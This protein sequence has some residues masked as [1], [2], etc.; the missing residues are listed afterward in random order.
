MRFG[1]KRRT[2]MVLLLLLT[3]A[4]FGS[5]LAGCGNKKATVVDMTGEEVAV[6]KNPKRIYVDWSEGTTLL[7]A[8]RATKKLVVAPPSFDTEV[9]TNMKSICPEI[10]SVEKDEEAYLSIEKA[11]SYEPDLVITNMKDNIPTYRDAGVAV[12]HV[13]YND[14]ETFQESLK[15]VGKALGTKAYKL[16]NSYCDYFASNEEMVKQKLKDIDEESKPSVYYI[17]ARYSDIYHT[18]GGGEFQETWITTAGGVL[19]TTAEYKG[20][21]L[22]LSA[23]EILSLNPDIILIGEWNQDK[24]YELL[25]NDEKL[26]ALK[27]VE[28]GRVYCVPRGISTWSGAGAEAALQML[29]AAKLFH[30]EKFADIDITEST[31]VF[32][33][34]IYGTKL[35]DDTLDSILSEK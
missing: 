15:I 4:V 12:I 27:A 30:P 7:M 8:L 20:I 11:L 31:K 17:D 9:Y 24:V 21:N 18:V 1:M 23:E 28:N 5:V 6:P 32:Y 10:S 34:E 26:G 14:N 29:W 35:R 16:A 22:Q 2:M 33:Q 25:M 13:R 19:A 3:V